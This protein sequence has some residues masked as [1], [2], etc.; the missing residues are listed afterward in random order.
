M[1]ALHGPC[2]L[3]FDE[4]ALRLDVSSREVERRFA[5]ALAALDRI[6]SASATDMSFVRSRPGDID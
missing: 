3:G 2:D 1:L 5:A 6:L 4:I